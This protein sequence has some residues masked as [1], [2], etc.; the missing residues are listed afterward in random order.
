MVANEEPRSTRRGK[1]NSLRTDCESEHLR[2]FLS[3]W[4]GCVH[5]TCWYNP[6]DREPVSASGRAQQ[7]LRLLWFAPNGRD[8]RAAAGRVHASARSGSCAQ[9]FAS[10][11]TQG[12]HRGTVVLV[13]V[14][15]FVRVSPCRGIRRCKGLLS[16]MGVCS[17]QVPQLV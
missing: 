16:N 5:I 17:G 3:D 15:R 6:S 8:A 13:E 12:N 10:C 11:Q 7:S 14:G 2:A 4:V 9:R 1:R